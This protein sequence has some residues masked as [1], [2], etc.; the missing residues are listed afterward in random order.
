M[1]TNKQKLLDY[2]VENYKEEEHSRSY[3]VYI[4]HK[5][6]SIYVDKDCYDDY[7]KDDDIRDLYLSYVVRG[8]NVTLS[9][10]HTDEPMINEI[11]EAIGER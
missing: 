5:D 11:L 8:A 10:I 1:N 4:V 6:M 3:R 2:Y 7:K 9:A